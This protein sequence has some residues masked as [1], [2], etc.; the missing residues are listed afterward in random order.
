MAGKG[1]GCNNILE[2][3]HNK[4]TKSLTFFLVDPQIVRVTN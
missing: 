1:T 3:K 2:R 4:I